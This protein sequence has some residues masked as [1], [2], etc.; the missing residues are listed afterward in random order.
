MPW[1]AGSGLLEEGYQ[2][3]NL[4]VAQPSDP[5][6][7]SDADLPHDLAGPDAADARHRLQ[8]RRDLHLA[9][10]VVVL[11]VRDHL[12]QQALGVLEAILNC[13]PLTT[14]DCRLCKSIG[15]LLRGELGKSHCQSPQGMNRVNQ[16]S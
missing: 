15:T 9:D 13:C 8:Q 14:S 16:S 3:G 2:S 6:G 12:G 1:K 4:V 7:L 11:A 10:D 5:A